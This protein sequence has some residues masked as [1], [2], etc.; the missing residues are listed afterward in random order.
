MV[1]LPRA[2]GWS[3]V[4]FVMIEYKSGVYY[5]H[6]LHRIRIYLAVSFIESFP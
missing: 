4:L 5:M 6:I 3:S 2:C 1:I